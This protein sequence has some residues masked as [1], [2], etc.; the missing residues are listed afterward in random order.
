MGRINGVSIINPER[1]TIIILPSNVR[2]FSVFVK[3]DETLAGKWSLYERITEFNTWNRIRSLSYNTKSYWEY[4]D[5]Y[6][7]GY[8][9]STEIDYLIDYS[10][11]K[12]TSLDNPIRT[13]VKIANIRIEDGCY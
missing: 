4:I 6:D 13:I 11:S 7:T 12:F 1:I 3:A 2:N 5:W 10:Y 9:E 8:N